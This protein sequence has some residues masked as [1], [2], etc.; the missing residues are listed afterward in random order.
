MLFSNSSLPLNFIF[1]W[2]IQSWFCQKPNNQYKHFCCCCN[3]SSIFEI[4]CDILIVL[5]FW[6]DYISNWE[7]KK[8]ADDVINGSSL[9]IVNNKANNPRYCS[10]VVLLESIP[11]V[12]TFIFKLFM[13]RRC[14]MFSYF[15]FDIYFA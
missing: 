8:L 10:H 5:K 2:K 12:S 13:H 11:W 9:I 14:I 4:R 3:Q 15:Y 1:Y 6:E 7:S